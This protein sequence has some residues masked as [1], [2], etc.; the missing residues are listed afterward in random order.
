MAQNEYIPQLTFP[1]FLAAV[2]V[3]FHHY[4]VG[5]FSNK[6]VNIIVDNG[7]VAVSFFF[8][9]SGMVLTLNYFEYS[10][11]SSK[12][13]YLKRFARIYPIYLFGIIITLAALILLFDTHPRG[14]SI[15]LQILALHAWTPGYCTDINF[16]GWSISVEIFFYLLF[17]LLLIL[18]KKLNLWKLGLFSLIIWILSI[19]QNYFFETHVYEF[20]N[21]VID[22]LIA[23]FPV[24]HLNAFIFGMFA[25]ALVIKIKKSNKNFSYFPIIIAFTGLILFLAFLA[26]N[27][28][29][30]L[31]IHNGLLSP[32]F[33]MI[34]TG[35]ALDKS[36]ISKILG[37]KSFVFLG[38]ISYGIYIL[39]YPVY[40][41]FSKICGCDTFNMPQFFIYLAVLVGTCSITYILIEKK[42]RK[43][44]VHLGTKTGA[45]KSN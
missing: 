42:L 14:L 18:F 40:L 22:D 33:F 43:K 26:Y 28:I 5:I 10:R 25:G 31:R 37:S 36:F 38:D 30:D 19:L 6:I 39:Q 44:I 15:M 41:V 9:L 35:L 3:V 7:P 32:V 20:G 21:K 2:M 17:P 24:W 23:F 12:M 8:F 27:K 16:P 45:A 34:L 29:P 11:F 13:F 4:G 1:R